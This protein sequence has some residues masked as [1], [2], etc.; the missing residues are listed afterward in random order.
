MH[1]K[2]LKILRRAL[3]EDHVNVAK[4]LQSIG[5]VYAKQGKLAEAL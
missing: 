4:S 5:I 3:G 2:A 1:E